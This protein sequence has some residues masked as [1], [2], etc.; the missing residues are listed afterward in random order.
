VNIEEAQQRLE[1][2]RTEIWRLNHAYFID[3][4]SIVSEDVRDA[5][6]QELLSLE[7]KYPSLITA[8]SPSQRVGA[9]LDGRLPKVQHLFPKESL[10]DAF[11]EADIVDW[12]VQ[13][14]RALD[15]LRNQFDYIVEQK[16]DGLNITLLYTFDVNR[17][18]FFLQR[19]TTRGNGIEG[20]DVTHTIKTIRSIPLEFALN[21]NALQ[22]IEIG[23]E[24]Y[25]TKDSLAAINSHMPSDKQFANPRNAAAGSVRQ[26]DPQMAAERNLQMFCYSIDILSADT[27]GI[28][29]QYGILE[30]LQSWG[31]A[32]ETSA[33]VYTDIQD[34]V[35]YY[36]T[37]QHQRA[38]LPY[39]IDGLVIKLNNRR[40]QHDLGS[41]AKAPRWARALK[42]PAEQK[43][44]VVEKITLQIGRTGAITPVAELTP[45][46]LAGTTVTRATL[47]NADEIRRL[48]V[49][50][51]DTVIVQKAGDIIPEVVEVLT[52]L[53]P[54]VTHSFEFPTQC[55]RCQTPLL[56]IDD[57]VVIRCPNEQ[58]TGRIQEHI[59]HSIS[60]YAFNIEGLGSETIA[61]LLEHKRIS[62]V[63]DI[64]SLQYEDLISLPL[65]KEKKTQNTLESIE[66]SKR[67]PLD[68]F[69][70][71]LGIRHIGRETAEILARRI[72]WKFTECTFT[73]KNNT[74][75]VVLS[76][77]DEETEQVQCTGILPR[78]ILHTLQLQTQSDVQALD[79]LGI[80]VAETLQ[81]WINE[82]RN[83]QLLHD[84]QRVGVI[85][86]PLV[87]SSVPQNFAGQTFVITGT[88]PTLSREEVKER[89]K[90]RGGKVSGS[91]SK[92]TTYVVVGDAAGSKKEDA[93]RLGIPLIDEKDFLAMCS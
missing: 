44:A 50:I 70:F 59:E 62:T 81:N 26:L 3:N 61:L 78:D 77:F 90:E 33:Q 38:D 48:D 1:K 68:R 24:V 28:Q 53:R 56:Q 60:R 20:E 23:G 11:S 49:R 47:H 9:P 40:M 4:T 86:L 17:Q 85:A 18:K 36:E 91:V 87:Q 43:T 27:L 79:G 66:K 52:A 16:I 21:T 41:T 35:R 75:G 82:S 14:E 57:E 92:N 37:I 7:R 32:V 10:T 2:L 13:M 8:D 80:A 93:D 15:C 89:I 76:L 42:F 84:L 72:P 19:A 58:C 6:K 30:Q 46:I 71:A 55:P 29:T 12:I 54:S 64:F 45:T 69:L 88:L 73:Q 51:G 39:D 65:F 34:I 83:I 63:A 74:P 22:Q 31:F 25:I 67:I 5:L